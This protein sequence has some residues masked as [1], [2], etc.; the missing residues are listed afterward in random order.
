MVGLLAASV[1]GT[2]AFAAEPV[3]D[4]NKAHEQPAPTIEALV[5]QHAHDNGVPVGLAK[6]VIR[7]ESRFNPR[8]SNRGAFG[9]MQIKAGTAR[10]HG[11]AG[12]AAGLFSPDTN[13]RYGMKVL[14]EA[15]RAS[16][17]DVC[18][19]L[20]FY[21]SGHRVHRFSAAQ[22]TYCSRARAMMA[23]I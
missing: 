15:Y 3:E 8:A 6:A 2:F 7:I 10:S 18:R 1:S 21:Q 9:L 16:G 22:R 20:A 23:G 14:A 11:F 13:L 17:G 12:S 4:T 5:T 19:T